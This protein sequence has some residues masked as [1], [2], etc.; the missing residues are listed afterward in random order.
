VLRS[1]EEDERFWTTYGDRV[2]TRLD[3][4]AAEVGA[5]FKAFSSIG[6]V[7]SVSDRHL[8][9]EAHRRSDDQVNSA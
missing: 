9:T 6:L 8:I 7:A 1:S 5:S 2:E 4:A 3:A